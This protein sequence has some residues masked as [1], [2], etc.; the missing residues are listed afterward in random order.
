MILR[1]LRVSGWRCFAEP[2]IL[3]PLG[4]G[5]NLVH[6]PNGSGKST[7]F[8]ALRRGLLETHALKAEELR[9]WGRRLAPRVEVEFLQDGV[10]YRGTKQFLDAPSCLVERLEQGR[11]VPL[12]QGKEGDRFLLDLFGGASGRGSAPAVRWGI[13]QILWAPQGSLP[14][15]PLG[16]GAAE[17][18]K[19]ALGAEAEGPEVRRLREA[20]E[21]RYREH[22]TPTG[23]L[24]TGAQGAPLTRLQEDRAAQEERVRALQGDVARYD[25]LV[26]RLDALAAEREVLEERL[27]GVDQR[28]QDL[29]ARVEVF[30][31]KVARR[32]RSRLAE[33]EVRRH[34]DALTREERL[35]REDRRALEAVAEALDA[36]TW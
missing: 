34:L 8:E 30:R 15:E 20:L 2:W 36:L 16:E 31:E 14:L 4:E 3:G 35:L 9:P 23:R 7:L 18:L 22:F 21:A 6:A 10:A 12:A 29:E 28:R 11:F 33:E 26:A 17:R 27:R 19:A 32:D 13:H 5:L 24:R 25:E 1:S